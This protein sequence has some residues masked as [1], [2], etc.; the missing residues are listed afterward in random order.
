VIDREIAEGVTVN[1]LRCG[2][3]PCVTGTRVPTKAVRSFAEAGYGVAGIQ[4]EY[5]GLSPEQIADALA[6]EARPARERRELSRCI[7]AAEWMKVP[8]VGH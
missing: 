4:R 3:R 5:P 1:P 7:P 8:S 2:G 6:F